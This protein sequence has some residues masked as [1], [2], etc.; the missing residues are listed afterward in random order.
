[1]SKLLDLNDNCVTLTGLSNKISGAFV[2]DATTS[3][4]IV[5]STGATIVNAQAMPYVSGSDGVYQTVILST[6]VLGD[7]VTVTINAVAGDGSVFQVTEKVYV[8][9][10]KL[11]GT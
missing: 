11:N 10:R 7:A 1:M 2:N 3:V 4:T 8:S 6:V 9:S 5:D